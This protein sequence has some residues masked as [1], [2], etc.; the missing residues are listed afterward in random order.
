[1]FP[2]DLIYLIPTS[3]PRSGLM[4]VKG[5][6]I[7][8]TLQVCIQHP[9]VIADPCLGSGFA[10]AGDGSDLAAVLLQI[11][12]DVDPFQH[13]LVDDG[14]VRDRQ[15]QEDWQPLVCHALVLAGT[16]D[17]HV[18]ISCSPVE[19][20]RFQ[21][22]FRPFRDHIEAAVGAFAYGACDGSGSLRP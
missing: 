5:D 17:L 12:P 20:Q 9:G 3:E 6:A 11:R 13:G 2:G 15:L 22:P 10:A 21:N 8:H 1:M 19:R 4:I 7:F 18:F 14:F 16:A